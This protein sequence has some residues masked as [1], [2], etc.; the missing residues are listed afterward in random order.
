MAAATQRA[1][2][3]ALANAEL[4]QDI[5]GLTQR[6]RDAEEALGQT[7]AVMQSQSAQLADA[8]HR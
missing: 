6:L 4:T 5:Q 7:R 2:Q 8:N 1:E 3:L